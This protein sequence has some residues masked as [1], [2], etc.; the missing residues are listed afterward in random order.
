MKYTFA[1]AGQ[2]TTMD[3]L[4]ESFGALVDQAKNQNFVENEEYNKTKSLIRIL[5]T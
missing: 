2:D 3:S 1:M 4:V 5:P